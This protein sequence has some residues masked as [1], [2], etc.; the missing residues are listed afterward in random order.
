M[1][2]TAA[3]EPWPDLKPKIA[4]E[5]N[6]FKE[7]STDIVCF[8]S[9]CKMYFSYFNQFFC[10][11][12]H[13]VVFCTSR[14]K[15]EVQNWWEVVARE[16]G[17][18]DEGDQRYLSYADFKAEVRRR[19]WKDSDTK[20]KYAQWEKL[21]QVNFKDGDLFFQK[22]KSL[23]FEARV[24]GNECIMCAQVKKTGTGTT[25]GG[26]GALMDIDRMHTK[27]KCFQCSK[28]GHFKCDCPDS[29]KTRKEAMQRLNN[30]WDRQ[31]TQEKLTESKIKEVKNGA[32]Q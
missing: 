3:P 24:F 29:P 30:Y 5:P 20:I 26:Q 17:E 10:H 1:L 31:A 19:F 4:R 8:F 9:Q 11:H 22:F 12:P 32:E 23:A 13:K 14:F 28:L 16:L 15:S 25:Y 18:S 6:L 27:V 21:C 2:T 7:E